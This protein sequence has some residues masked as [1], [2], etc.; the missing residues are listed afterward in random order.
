MGET[1]PKKE[2]HVDDKKGERVDDEGREGDEKDRDA[3]TASQQR[4]PT[5]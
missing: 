3:L 5:S 4:E 2:R 1:T